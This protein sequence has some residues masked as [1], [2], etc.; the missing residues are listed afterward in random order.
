MKKFKHDLLLRS[1][2]LLNV[3][4]IVIPFIICW[5]LYYLPHMYKPFYSKGNYLILILYALLYV[6]F[7][8]IYE[9]FIISIHKFSEIVCSQILSVAITDI[10]TYLMIWLLSRK[11]PHILPILMAMVIQ[12]SIS[13]LWTVLAQKWY[14]WKFEPIK[15]AIIYDQ[16]KSIED[17]IYECGLEKKYDVQVTE[18]IS[19]CLKDLAI[20]KNVKTV[21]LSGIHSHDR[22][23]ILKYCVLHNIEVL[24]IPRIGDVIMSGAHPYHIFHLPVLSVGRYKANPEYLLLKRIMDILLSLMALIIFMPLILIV[25]VTIKVEDGGPVFYKQTRLTKN[26]KRFEILKFRSMCV[27]AE[28]DGVARLSVGNKDNRITAV[29]RI[30]RRFRIDEIPQLLN[31]LQGDLTI[32]G[33]RPER[34]EIAKE[35]CKELPEFALRLQVKAGLT[36]YAQVYGKYNTTPFDKLQMD[37]M[38]IAHPSILEDLKIMLATIKILFVAESTEGVDVDNITAVTKYTDKNTRK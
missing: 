16:F 29:G 12:L 28:K 6:I 31:I 17:L 5:F 30:I 24:V 26:G 32:C 4:L 8:R 11:L 20:L 34:P 25:S 14:F 27:D 15:M 22:N 10:I 3:I 37:L 13:L 7:G 21:F 36:G 33:P 9:A 1:I 23:I 38:Y 18:H 2:K 35:Y 19:V